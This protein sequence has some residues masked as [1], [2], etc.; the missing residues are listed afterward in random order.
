MSKVKVEQ[1]V[2]LGRQEAAAWLAEMAKVIGDGGSGELPLAGPTV[3]LCLPHEL[4][5]EIELELDGDEIELEIELKWANSR[6]EPSADHDRSSDDTDDTTSKS[7]SSA[8]P[9]R[10]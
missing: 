8:K 1:K 9:A 6:A 7:R 10:T 2:T 3:A 4:R 5:C